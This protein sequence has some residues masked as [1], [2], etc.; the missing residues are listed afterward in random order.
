MTACPFVTAGHPF[1]RQIQSIREAL[2]SSPEAV[3]SAKPARVVRQHELKGVRD[4]SGAWRI[5]RFYSSELA[6][7]RLDGFAFGA[8]TYCYSDKTGLGEWF[9]FP[10]DPYLGALDHLA[11][12][13][14]EVL[15]YVVLRRLTYRAKTAEGE[16]RIGKFK[17]KSRARG[18]FDVLSSVSAAARRRPVSF[19]VPAPLGH[20]DSRHLFHQEALAGA[21]VS[22]LANAATADALLFG[23]GRVQAELHRLDVPGLPAADERARIE[24]LSRECD[25][26]AFFRPADGPRLAAIHGVLVDAVPR[27]APVAAGLCHGDFVCSHVL[28]GPDGWG[29]VD[30]DLAHAGDPHADAASLLSSLTHDVPYFHR[31]WRNADGLPE[32]LIDR[33]VAAY[34]EGYHSYA[35]AALDQKRLLWH[36]IAAEIHLLGLMFTKDR[37]HALAF[38]R[39]MALIERLTVELSCAGGR[40]G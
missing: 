15:Q 4:A 11:E 26:I 24:L 39:S 40:R 12:V 35:G 19:R 34:V 27:L 37:F 1:E 9:R 32:A 20:D 31:A 18:A 16:T 3:P 21:P 17:R 5:D 30:F 38:D 7:D 23:V 33:A 2:E 28:R 22:E 10:R 14:A 36:R 13:D 8:A 29:V 25:W 6:W